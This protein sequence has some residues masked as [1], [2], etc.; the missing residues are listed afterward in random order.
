[1]SE[2]K[3][4]KLQ[5]SNNTTAGKHVLVLS[6]HPVIALS[7]VRCLAE[8]GAKCII[9]GNERSMFLATSRACARFI[10]I[11][12]D[13]FEAKTDILI[14]AIEQTTAK[15]EIASVFPSGPFSTRFLYQYSDTIR[16]HAPIPVLSDHNTFDLLYDKHR[17][18]QLLDE[19]ELPQPK[20]IM[21]GDFSEIETIRNS[22]Q[23]PALLKPT[24]QEGGKGIFKFESFKALESHVKQ[25]ALVSDIFPIIVQ[26]YIPGSDIDLSVYAVNGKILAW[27]VQERVSK[28]IFSFAS[29]N[30][31]LSIGKKIVASLNYSGPA[32]FDMRIDD[33][34]G[35]IKVIECNPRFWATLIESCCTGINF[36]SIYLDVTNGIP[37]EGIS[38]VPQE[39][40]LISLHKGLKIMKNVPL[41]YNNL[42]LGTL[43]TLRHSNTQELLPYIFVSFD[44]KSSSIAKLSHKISRWMSRRKVSSFAEHS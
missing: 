40:N 4:P 12:D 26:E 13:A 2:L 44:D 36:A 39:T 42:S 33:R 35:S 43:A 1:M 22:I 32:H 16:Q 6:D 24:M 31:M 19:E 34:N 38:L 8:H 20:T 5:N 17:F 7:I 25:A 30:E 10:H 41:D 18:S 23:F 27:T 37:K 14:K 15:H 21:I 9:I 28:G 3:A 11:P 29:N